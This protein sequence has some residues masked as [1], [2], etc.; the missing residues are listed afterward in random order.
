MPVLKPPATAPD[1]G[2]SQKKN[3]FHQFA[4]AQLPKSDYKYQ[5]LEENEIRL[6][7]LHAAESSTDTIVCSFKTVNLH[8]LN[9][10][11]DA[12]SYTWG[13]EEPTQKIVL[14]T[15]W[16]RS[17]A[18]GAARLK[19]AVQ[20]LSADEHGIMKSKVYVRPN[21]EDV[22][23]Q[24]RGTDSHQEDLFIWVDAMC[25]DQ[26]DEKEKSAQVAKMAEIYSKARDVL[27]WLGKEYNASNVAM[28]FIPKILDLEQS[29]LLISKASNRN[30]WI[31]FADLMKREWFSRRWVVQEVALAKQRFMY[32][33]TK[34]LN[35][36]DFERAVS[37]FTDKVDT[38]L[39]MFTSSAEFRHNAKI[40]EEIRALGSTAMVNITNDYFHWGAD[41]SFQRLSSLEKLVASLPMFESLD[42]RDTIFGLLSIAS[43]TRDWDGFSTQSSRSGGSREQGRVELE[44]DYTKTILE[45]FKDFTAFCVRTSSSLDIICRHWAPGQFWSSNILYRIKKKI[46]NEQSEA[47]PSVRA[48]LEGGKFSPMTEVPL[49]SW[50]G[51]LSR[52]PYGQPDGG[53]KIRRA[54]ESLVGAPDDP[55]QRYR[56]SRDTRPSVLFGEIDSSHDPSKPQQYD[57]GLTDIAASR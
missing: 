29:D 22:L 38:I 46:A 54:G 10:V 2:S 9:Q 53:T 19:N 56:A 55:G 40:L 16:S 4:E 47:D 18:T 33:G 35:W 8:K 32:C 51:L 1:I 26:D 42:P 15:R 23:R 30:Q 34:A 48:L 50:I 14:H 36:S 28:G 52:S 43:D 44:A 3:F 31:A 39:A 20:K 37:F 5:H 24:F 41:G 25:I 6:L 7:R 57:Q 12:L 49:P 45:V 13:T 27:I 17:T 11:Y 21:L